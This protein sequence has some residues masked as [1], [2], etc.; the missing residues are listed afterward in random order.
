MVSEELPVAAPH[1]SVHRGSDDL[2]SAGLGLEGLRDAV[3]PAVANADA[4]TAAELRRRAFHTNWRGIADLATGR[5]LGDWAT[6][7]PN[8]PGR[9]W[10]GFATLPGRVH[11]HRL[12]VQVPDDFN[13]SQRCLVV[14]ASSGSRG[15]YG[16]IA[17]AGA[18]GLPKGCAVAYTDKGAGTGFY[19]IDR[20]EGA[21]LDGTRIGEGQFDFAPSLPASMT[22]PPHRVALKHAHSGDNP[23]A[24]WGRH[25]LQAAAFGLQALND[26]FPTQAPF[27]H[28]NTRI[29]AVGL[30][31]GGAAVLRAAELDEQGMFDAV[32][33]AAPNI[34]APASGR[35]LF[36]YGTE[37]ALYVPCALPAISNAVTMMPP[38]ARDA[39]SR[40]R[41]AS[42]HQA[43]LLASGDAAAQPKEALD[44][45][46]AQGWSSKAIALSE[47]STAFDLWRALGATY[48]QSYARA[49]IDDPVCGYGFAMLAADGSARASTAAERALW[50]SDAS[51]IAPTVGIG[52]VDTL[53]AGTD[54]AFPALM[55][56]R[57]LWSGDDAL[58]QK[59]RVGIAGTRATARLLC[60][61]VHIL[62]G[63][64]DGLI[65]IDFSSRPYVRAVRDNGLAITS[66]E[67]PDAQH[68]DAFVGFPAMS[69]YQ[70]L[71]P[72]VY[73]A[74][75]AALAD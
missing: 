12:L 33:A 64:D 37:A 47:Q 45:L 49:G 44:Y 30:S 7:F 50:W 20:V 38:A 11:P 32:V 69:R 31:N 24:D 41:C 66:T 1:V 2:F 74:L 70:P 18:W 5:G 63:V 23:E 34:L 27:T 14:T 48:A 58:A 67:V 39:V 26:A 56:L 3:A 57:K 22:R 36:D 46:L 6:K 60:D 52:I 29:I 40:Q 4:P 65:P 9:E 53:A 72:H 59:L 17:V 68:F 13:A 42:L 43:G 28:A 19:D 35:A 71:L 75:D 15:I 61:S 10:S 55:C 51:G 54:P 73:R 62:H 16:A 21:L 25:V 8:V